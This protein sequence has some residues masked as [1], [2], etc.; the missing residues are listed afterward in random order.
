M[1]QLHDPDRDARLVQSLGGTHGC[2]D[3]QATNVLPALLQQRHKVVDGQHDVGDELILRHINV[4]DRDTQ[5]QHLLQLELD[6]A[7]DLSDLASQILSVGDRRR[8]LAS[9]GQTR[10]QK[11]RD[12]LDQSLG[13]DKGI[14]LVGELLDQLLVLVE[15]LQIV[16]GHGVNAVVLGAVDVVL[17]TENTDGHARARDSGQL[18]GAGETLVTLRVIVLEADLEFDGLEEVALLGVLGVIE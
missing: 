10:T 1:S 9:L 8:E 14:V 5:A 12:L 4:A 6:R 15:L 18:D 16:G 2:L 7:L 13:G 17:V 3:D 11:T